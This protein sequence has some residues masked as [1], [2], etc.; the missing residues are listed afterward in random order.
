MRR[1]VG[2]EP[3]G[4]LPYDPLVDR[5]FSART[6]LPGIKAKKK[7]FEGAVAELLQKHLSEVI[8]S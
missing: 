2:F 7:P 8:L 4:E 5:M 6:P 1:L 3:A